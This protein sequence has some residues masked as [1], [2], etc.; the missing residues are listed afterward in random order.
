[1]LACLEIVSFQIFVS[2]VCP[3]F[4]ILKPA[5][6]LFFGVIISHMNTR[7]NELRIVLNTLAK[8]KRFIPI[9]RMNLRL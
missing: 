2:V 6:V 3:A 4:I 8:V 7:K 9:N 5:F 1:M